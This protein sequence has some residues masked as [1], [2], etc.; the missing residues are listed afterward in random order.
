MAAQIGLA[1]V[2]ASHQ[3]DGRVRLVEPPDHCI[4]VRL[5]RQEPIAKNAQPRNLNL[6]W[7]VVV[8]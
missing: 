6:R 5:V 1:L 3:N 4:Q 8:A 7:S 2:R